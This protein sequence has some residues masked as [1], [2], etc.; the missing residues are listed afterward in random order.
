MFRSHNVLAPLFA[1][2]LLLDFST[3]IALAQSAPPGQGS[4]PTETLHTRTELVIVDVVVQDRDGHA[5]PGLTRDNFVLSEQKKP[6]TIRNFEEHSAATQKPG[7]AMPPMPPGV[8]TDYTPVKPGAMN[9]LLIDMLNTPMADQNNLRKQLLDFVKQEKPGT[10]VAIFVLASHVFV[11]QGFTTDPAILRKALEKKLIAQASPLLDDAV[12][13]GT[14]PESLAQS[15]GEL[16]NQD[17]AMLALLAEVDQDIK[18]Y[19]QMSRA[20]VTL[21]AFN[22]IGHYLSNFPGRKNLVWFSGSFPFSIEPDPTTNND[23]A[24][25]ENSHEE[26]RETTNLM[27]RAQI[28]VYPI[29]ARGLMIAPALQVSDS[30]GAISSRQGLAASLHEFHEAQIAEHATMEEVADDTGGQAFFNTNGLTAATGKALDAGSSYYTLTYTPSDHNQNGHYREIKVRLAGAPASE[31]LRLFYRHG[32]Y[33]DNPNH[34]AKDDELA[35]QSVPTGTLADHPKEA[36]TR[37]AISHGAPAPEDILFKVQ[38]APLTGKDEDKV[39]AGNRADP[40]K[41]KAPYLAYAVDYLA[42]P[43]E[44]NMTPGSD[45]RH[46]GAIEFTTYVYDGEGNMLNAADKMVPLDLAPETYKRFMSTPVRL[47][48]QVSAPAKRESY[49]RVVIRDVPTNRYGV[50]EIPTADVRHL[51]TFESQMNP[52]NAAKPAS[53]TAAAQPTTKQ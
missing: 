48:L 11:L 16:G 20:E 26:L 31:S 22:S 32:Y 4:T 46:K 41:M 19:Q 13:G 39:E 8:F 51:P 12:G 40:A 21:D 14:G 33:A 47:H 38:A 50:V 6:Q 1:F 34:L 15:A 52:A 17:A 29:D 10:Q 5:V 27:T 23:F 36:Y 28:A 3:A 24:A 2:G 18:T 43:K 44:F 49:L 35:T 9:V 53:G 42:L 30:S 25:M 7:P 45:G 37:A